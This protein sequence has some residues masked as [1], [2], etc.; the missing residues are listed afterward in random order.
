MY[1][2]VFVV[3]L[4]HRLA[5]CVYT[6]TWTL[7]TVNLP[8]HYHLMDEYQLYNE[9][10]LTLLN[11]LNASQ[12]CGG[13]NEEAARLI[14]LDLAHNAERGS[15]AD[16]HHSGI[17]YNVVLFSEDQGRYGQSEY[18]CGGIDH[19]CERQL[20]IVEP[21]VSKRDAGAKSQTQ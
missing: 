6:M 12:H 9:F 4:H 16:W 18:W 10:I 14:E 21:H 3:R 20:N 1:L 2:D 11:G 13:D 17:L 5:Y 19:L 8:L 7:R 15:E